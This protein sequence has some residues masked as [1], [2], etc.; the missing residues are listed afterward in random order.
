[1]AKYVALLRGINV[2]GKNMIKM[3]KLR[4]I[5]AAL[6]LENVKTYVN[7]GNVIFE[8][9]KTSDKVLAAKVHNAIQKELG[10]NISVMVRSVAGIEEI[11]AKNP[12]DGKF[13]N[14]KYLHVFFLSDELSPEHREMLLANNSDVEFITLDGRTVYYMLRISIVDSSL[15]KG[16][17]DRKLKVPST[18]RNWRTVNKIAEM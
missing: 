11:I 6:G 5:V 3:E 7:S 18:A 12:Y 4:E 9:K 16:F 1:M 8:T 13:E 14:D 17:I 2:G 15:G 10:L